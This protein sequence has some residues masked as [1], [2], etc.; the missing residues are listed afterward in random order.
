MGSGEEDESVEAGEVEVSGIPAATLGEDGTSTLL[1]STV[2]EA[3]QT[4]HCTSTY[5]LHQ[6]HA[7][8]E[9]RSQTHE[10]FTFQ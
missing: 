4:G 8:K 7:R 10:S 5:T 2:I 1:S 3:R 9:K 6:C